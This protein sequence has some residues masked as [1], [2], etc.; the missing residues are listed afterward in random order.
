[1]S[2]AWA[3]CKGVIQCHRILCESMLYH[4]NFH[5]PWSTSQTECSVSMSYNS[6]ARHSTTIPCYTKWIIPTT[7]PMDCIR[8]VFDREIFYEIGS[9][10]EIFIHFGLLKVGPTFVPYSLVPIQHKRNFKTVYKQS[11]WPFLQDFGN[12]KLTMALDTIGN[13]SN[14]NYQQKPHLVYWVMGRGW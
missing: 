14:N 9:K 13:Y 5:M 8:M 6:A 12:E 11:V 7:Q 1:M 2:A 3:E 4:S 10:W